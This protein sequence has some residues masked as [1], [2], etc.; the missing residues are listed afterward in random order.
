MD[1]LVSALPVSALLVFGRACADQFWVLSFVKI[2]QFAIRDPHRTWL[3]EFSP[4]KP[5]LMILRNSREVLDV[6]AFAST[7]GHVPKSLAWKISLFC[8][9]RSRIA[10]EEAGGFPF[11]I[12]MAVVVRVGGV[13]RANKNP[14][15]SKMRE[16]FL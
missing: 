2:Q 1:R 11:L 9:T 16:I 6:E 10:C 8:D 12:W 3:I 14:R 13:F 5:R 7:P 4:R 15:S